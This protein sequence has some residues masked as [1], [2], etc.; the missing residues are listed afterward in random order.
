MERLNC[1]ICSAEI[2]ADRV[3]SY[4]AY[5]RCGATLALERPSS[6]AEKRASLSLIMVTILMAGAVT[7]YFNW[8]QHFFTIIPAKVKQLTGLANVADLQKI[9]EICTE[10]RKKNCVA[11]A[12]EGLL[13]KK[14]SDLA[15]QLRLAHLYFELKEPQK[16]V[17]V[18][19]SYFKD[20][21]QDASARYTFAKA[22]ADSGE[23]KEA[24][25]QFHYILAHDR[26]S[27]EFRVA[28]S[29]VELLVRNREY[30]LAK[31]VI[32]EYR[33]AGSAS[34]MFLERE[35]QLINNKLNPNNRE[36]ARSGGI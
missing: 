11:Q 34:A 16:S 2:P 25:K 19:S 9:A 4:T 14:P 17:R 18:F 29:Y 5:C 28:R 26:K 30:T 23:W 7:H 8:D 22:L 36:I 13:A 31:T 32:E 33:Q 24:K 15:N 12:L 6:S 35:W 21:G 3:V 1:T 10:R 27:P 20:G